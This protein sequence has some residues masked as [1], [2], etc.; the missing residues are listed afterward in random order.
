MPA[1]K[2]HQV[3]ET[4]VGAHRNAQRLGPLYSTAHGTG[5]A[6]MEAR[7]DVRGADMAHQLDVDAIANGP[8]AKPLTHV[9]VEIHHLH[10]CFSWRL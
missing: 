10:D 4:R 6:G 3:S 7:G 5:V 1:A 8:R 9:R 2:A